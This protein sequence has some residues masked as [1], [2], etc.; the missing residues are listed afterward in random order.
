MARVQHGGSMKISFTFKHLKPSQ[1][2]EEY[3]ELRIAKL[4]KFALKPLH[5]K[6]IFDEHKHLQKAEAVITGEQGRQTAQAAEEN[7]FAAIDE[8]VDKLERQLCKRKEKVQHHKKKQYRQHKLELLMPQAPEEI[9]VFEVLSRR[10][11]AA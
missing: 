3:A 1:K 4:D 7:L 8:V 10:K 2:V 11:R 6:F 5:V 9:E